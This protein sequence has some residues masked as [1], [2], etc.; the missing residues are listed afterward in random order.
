[1]GKLTV[2]RGGIYHALS[3]EHGEGWQDGALVVDASG[4][5]VDCGLWQQVNQKIDLSGCEQVT[6]QPGQCILPGMF[7]LHTHLPQYQVTGCEAADLGQWLDAYILP[8]EAR[9]EDTAYAAA[10]ADVFFKQ[11]LAKGTTT[12][13][14]F[15]TSHVEATTLAFE[16]A[17]RYGNRVVMGLNLMDRFGE[18]DGPEGLVRPVAD[19]LRD[20]EDLYQ[21]WHGANEGRL[22]YAWMPRY[23]ASCSDPLLAGVGALYRKYPEAYCHTHISEQLGEIETVLRLFPQVETYTGVYEAAG[24]LGPKTLLA[25]G[26]HLSQQ[27]RARIREHQSTLVH[28]P[29]ANFFLKS[30]RFPLKEMLADQVKLGLGTDVGAGPSL[31]LFDVM[32]DAVYMQ[33]VGPASIGWHVPFYLATL[34]GA[35]ALGMADRLGNFLPGKAADFVVA[36]LDQIPE[37]NLAQDWDVDE[38]LPRLIYSGDCSRVVKTYI[39]GRLVYEKTNVGNENKY[40]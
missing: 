38:M 12:A 34:G 37:K 25:H 40:A 32:R 33:A 31:S 18:G 13:A 24:L 28:C 11:L 20:T 27:E 2:Y 3:P 22:Q 4:T 23:A 6:L 26:V 30:G 21:T 8:E 17:A 29:S 1:M 39:E 36:A 19:L 7:D 35:E 16:T 10:M 14:V 5:I 15:L 9:F